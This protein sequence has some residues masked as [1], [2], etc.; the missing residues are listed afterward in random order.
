MAYLDDV[1]SPDDIKKMAVPE[2]EILAEE[3]RGAILKRCSAIGGHVGSNLGMV[4]ATIALHYVFSSPK[5]KIVFDVSHQCY[6]HKLLTGRKEGF[7]NPDEYGKISG[8]TNPNESEHDLFMVGHTSTSLSLAAGLAKARDLLNQKH[9]VIAVIGDGSLS[10]GEA[11]EGL[12]FAGSELKSNLIVVVND[13]GMSMVE[14]HGGIYQ[15]LELLKQTKGKATLNIFKALGYDY[16]YV[17][18]GNDVEALIKAFREVKDCTKP[19]VVHLNTVKGKGYLP[20]EENKEQWHKHQPFEVATGM[21]P[22]KFQGQTYNDL[23][24]DYFMKCLD[25]GMPLAVVTAA[26]P[27]AFGFSPEVRQKFGKNYIDVGIAEDYATSMVTALAKGCCKPVF[28][29]QSSFVQRAY[30]Q[31]LHDLALN[32]SP[33]L[34]LIY[35]CGLSDAD[36]THLG[37]FDVAM[38]TNIPNMLYLSPAMAEEYMM[39][40][41]WAVKQTDYP[42]AMRVPS[43]MPVFGNA[44]HNEKLELHRS[45]VIN[46][47]SKIAVITDGHCL[48]KGKEVIMELKKY[49]F[50]S[51]LVNARFLDAP[52]E[53][54]FDELEKDHQIIVT[55]EDGIVSGGFGEKVTAFYGAKEMKVL[56]YGGKKEFTN[57]VPLNEIY[58]KNRLNVSQ[59][60]EDILRLTGVFEPLKLVK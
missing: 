25:E 38:I 57:R 35:N 4:E 8:F 58:E 18:E 17:D 48:A 6:A 16:L 13:N 55:I 29:V 36:A 43:G 50:C 37:C 47:G 19:V 12:S 52:D 59:I 22:A 24:R 40:L 60:V 46:R 41:D 44:F 33:A 28:C 32:K 5:D 1:F 14:N 11:M 21:S 54:L 23:T 10:G 26:T 53:Q 3:M 34:I 56:N 27:N 45:Q 20:A 15:N 49:G 7:L 31:I 42:V 2:L 51:T 39:M 30:D 9:N